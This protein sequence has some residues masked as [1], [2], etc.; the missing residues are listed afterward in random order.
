MLD[1]DVL[2]YIYHHVKVLQYKVGWDEAIE[3]MADK[4]V[5]SPK[6]VSVLFRRAQ[7]GYGE[8]FNGYMQ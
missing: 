6:D 1:K 7:K 8:I 2:Y 4:F 5:V 3:R